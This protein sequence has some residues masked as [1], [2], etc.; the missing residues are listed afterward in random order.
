MAIQVFLSHSAGDVPEDA[1]FLDDLRTRLAAVQAPDGTAQFEIF[2]DRENLLAGDH[3][4]KKL[5]E[6]LGSCHAGVVVLNERALKVDEFPWVHTEASILRWRLWMGEKLALILMLRGKDSAKLYAARRE[7]QPL[8]FDEIQFLGARKEYTEATLDE[9]AF[10]TLVKQLL[11]A[12]DMEPAKTRYGLLRGALQRW[13]ER[14]PLDPARAREWTEKLLLVGPAGLPR[15]IAEAVAPMK[16]PLE[17][18]HGLIAPWWVDPSSSC[19]LTSAAVEATPVAFAL[20][21]SD[22]QYTPRMYVHHACCLG[23]D[24]A[25]KVLPVRAAPG[26]QSTAEFLDKVVAEVRK[27]LIDAYRRAWFGRDD[28]SDEEINDHVASLL[29]DDPPQPTFVALPHGVA[30]DKAVAQ[31][32]LAKFP[33]VKLILMT[34]TPEQARAIAHAVPLEPLPDPVAEKA[35]LTRYRTTLTRLP[36]R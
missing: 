33:L 28:V 35:E 15:L 29:R 11:L 32:I 2:F 13:L 5:L 17:Q 16:E 36:E 26:V 21:G 6:T 30:A 3:W 18:A 20:N 1:A 8:G 10:G 7:W 14:V 31:E 25:W 34:Q 4:R 12:K 27:Q 19:L 22:I 9:A 24:V 23:P